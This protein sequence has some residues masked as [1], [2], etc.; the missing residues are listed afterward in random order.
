MIRSFFRR[1]QTVEVLIT[2]TYWPQD[3][4]IGSIVGG[5]RVTRYE[6]R[7]DRWFNVWGETL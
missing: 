4:R 1:T 2:I 6:L 3:Y 5:R 7:D